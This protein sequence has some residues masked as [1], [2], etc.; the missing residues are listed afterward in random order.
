MRPAPAA[1]EVP[2]VWVVPEVAR[3]GGGGRRSYDQEKMYDI[4]AI[5]PHRKDVLPRGLVFA[6]FCALPSRSKAQTQ[7]ETEPVK[8]AQPSQRSFANPEQAA[9]V[10]I[11]AANQFDVPSLMQIFGPTGG[12]FVASA[13]P[14]E[15]KK[16]ANAFAAKA[17]E[18][19]SVETEPQNPN[20]AI[21]V[22]GEEEWPFPIP[23]VKRNGKWYFDTAAGHHEILARR[24]GSNELDAITIC[25]G[26]AEA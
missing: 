3:R 26:Y 6:L 12:D 22:V 17:H 20:R 15:D 23:I 9:N 5:E 11:E 4:Q 16:I 21:V 14:V 1:S 10:L 13:D 19:N 18:K 7:S 8:S 24:I 25:R 2:P